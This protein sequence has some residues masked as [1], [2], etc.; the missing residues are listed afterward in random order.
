MTTGKGLY[1]WMKL[2][3][4][5]HWPKMGG[6]L[7]VYFNYNGVDCAGMITKIYSGSRLIETSIKIRPM[8]SCHDIGMGAGQM[9]IKTFNKEI[10]KPKS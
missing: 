6:G 8:Q 1:K 7:V 9:I 10:S 4:N 3:K 5:V 2:Q